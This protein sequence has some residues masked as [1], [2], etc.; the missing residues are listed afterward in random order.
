MNK[1]NLIN[2]W[3]CLK[4]IYRWSLLMNAEKLIKQSFFLKKQTYYDGYC[5]RWHKKAYF[6]MTSVGIFVIENHLLWQF[7]LSRIFY[8][9]CRNTN[10]RM[11]CLNILWC[12]YILWQFIDNS[13][14]KSTYYISFLTDI[15]NAEFLYFGF[16]LSSKPS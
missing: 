16:M 5:N 1:E 4:F 6:T 15:K 11:F 2:E 9:G 12:I 8:D 13:H 10:H 14:N 7:W 3:V